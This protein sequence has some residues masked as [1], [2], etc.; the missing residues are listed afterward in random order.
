MSTDKFND[1][2]DGS[3]VQRTSRMSFGMVDPD[4]IRDETLH[5]NVKTVYTYLVTYCSNVR[6]AYPSRARIARQT[7]LS[8]RS[9][10]GALKLGEQVGLFTIERR[11]DGKLNQTN[12]YLLH[13]FGGGYVADS[14]VGSAVVAPGVAQGLPESGAVV[15]PELDQ[16]STPSSIHTTSTSSNAVSGGHR[17]SSPTERKIYLPEDFSEYDDRHANQ[18]LVGAAV[19]AL[20]AAGLVLHPRAADSLGRELKKRREAGEVRAELVDNIRRWVRVAGTDDDGAGWIASW[21]ETRA[22]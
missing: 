11:R 19:A 8:V 3:P 5:K 12:V 7:G 18:Y 2:K 10:D 20:Q 9:V 13:D 15:A 4:V 21:P 6:S 14:G 22:A 16:P 1:S 17:T